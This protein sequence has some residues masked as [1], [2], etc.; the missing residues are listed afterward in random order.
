[1]FSSTPYLLVRSK[2]Y[3]NEDERSYVEWLL[4]AAQEWPRKLTKTWSVVLNLGDAWRRGEPTLS[5]Y[6]ER[7]LIKLE[8]ELGLKLCQRF[9]WQNTA[10][11]P[12]PAVW[13]TV[14]RVRVKP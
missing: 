9:A 5:L 3:R 11:L 12:A 1:M 8:D 2:E 13:V 14:R 7:L 4:C 10:K 6:Q